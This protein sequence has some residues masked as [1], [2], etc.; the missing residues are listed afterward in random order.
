MF[1]QLIMNEA[2]PKKAS[3]Y[4]Y[5]IFL[6]IGVTAFLLLPFLYGFKMESGMEKTDLYF[7]GHLHYQ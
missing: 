5:F 7:S 3:I 1:I 4:Q 2:L 6:I